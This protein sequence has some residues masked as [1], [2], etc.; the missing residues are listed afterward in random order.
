MKNPILFLSF[1]A[2]VLAGCASSKKPDVS[3]INPAP[4]AGNTVASNST[5]S[6]RTQDVIK[7]YPTGR[8]VDP[9]D[10]NTMYG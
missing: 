2:L 6:V 9:N 10:A 5:E 3:Y 8:Y 4:V 7:A 1:S